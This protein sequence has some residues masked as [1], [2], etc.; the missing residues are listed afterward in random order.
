MLQLRY[1]QHVL[2][3]LLKL[4]RFKIPI[5]LAFGHE[6]VA[7]ALSTVAESDD[8]VCVSHRNVAY[9]LAR[10]KEFKPI[11][12]L[13][14]LAGTEEKASIVSMNLALNSNGVS[15]ASSILGN[16]LAVAAGIAMNRKLG[17][18]PGIAFAVTGDGAIEEGIFWEVLLHARSHNLPLVI[19]VEDNDYSLASTV[20]ER[21]CPIDL[22][23]VCE[24]L[25]VAF[26]EANG[27]SYV[28]IERTLRF[29]RQRAVAGQPV[30]VSARV[31]T[32]CQHAGP[33][34]GWPGDSLDI[35]LNRGMILEED[36]HDPLFDIR[37]LIGE[38]IFKE[39]EDM[40]VSDECFS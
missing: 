12:D 31:K 6:A 24:G 29:A 19:L 1:R 28:D 16:N 14:D 37:M 30:C 3:E 36:G 40:V 13:Y 39:L 35:D 26:Q 33:T 27:A 4:R 22:R 18:R 10:Q 25:G 15:D 21:R 20:A 9:N 5:H 23:L 32:Y 38:V 8:S 7:V 2:N 34:P 17:G 11:L